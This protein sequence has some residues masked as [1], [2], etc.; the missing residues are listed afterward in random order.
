MMVLKK[1]VFIVCYKRLKRVSVNV[2]DRQ[3]L[4]F[5][6]NYLFM[7]TFNFHFYTFTL[8]ISIYFCIIFPLQCYPIYLHKCI[9]FYGFLFTFLYAIVLHYSNKGS[10]FFIF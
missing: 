4:I 5:Q 7:L 1:S 9:L 10:L 3:A 2:E 6:S 8:Y